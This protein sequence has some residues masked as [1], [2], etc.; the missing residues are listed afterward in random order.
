[1]NSSKGTETI[2]ISHGTWSNT[3]NDPILFMYKPFVYTLQQIYVNHDVR[4]IIINSRTDLNRLPNHSTFIFIGVVNLQKIDWNLL[5]SRNIKCVYYSTE[6][7]VS[8]TIHTNR[9]LLTNVDEIWDFSP[10]NINIY[11]EHYNIT[12]FKPI[13]FH[14]NRPLIKYDTAR[15][16]K[17]VFLGGLMYGTRSRHYSWLHQTFPIL[18][19]NLININDAFTEEIFDSKLFRDTPYI[20]LNFHKNEPGNNNRN[21][22]YAEMARINYLMSSKALIISTHC[23][24]LDENLLNNMVTFCSLKNIASEY[25]NLLKMTPIQREELSVRRFKLFKDNFSYKHIQN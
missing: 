24:D 6:H 23:S 9:R 20:F 5:K 18:R 11:K 17:L 25:E 3:K 2:I 7:G 10:T 16:V 22:H 15:E 1:M 12:L 21:N 19:N 14:E 8:L 4:Y 13:I